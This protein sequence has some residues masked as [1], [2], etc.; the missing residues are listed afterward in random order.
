MRGAGS[1]F[2][3]FT[4]EETE[5]EKLDH[6]HGVILEIRGRI[7]THFFLLHCSEPKMIVNRNEH[8]TPPYCQQQA[9]WLDTHTHTLM[10]THTSYK[11]FKI[12][13]S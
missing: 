4:D 3:H 9:W 6:L 7:Q 12:C 8:L 11:I 10:H 2:F 1:I 5:S 13:M